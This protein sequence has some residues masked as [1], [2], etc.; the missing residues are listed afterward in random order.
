MNFTR[1]QFA[2]ACPLLGPTVHPLPANISGPQLLWA[3]GGNESSFGTNCTPRHE[4]AFDREGA[5][6]R[7]PDQ[8][9]LLNLYES[10]GAC[11]YG[12]LQIMLVNAKGMAPHDFD[13]LNRAMVASIQFLNSQL[14]RFKPQTLSQ[15]GA[16]WNGGSPRAMNPGVLA[17]QHRLMQNYNVPLGGA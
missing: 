2:A 9:N 8:A 7:E 13:D 12:P 4:P 16:L 1:Q 14:D 3:L 15:I 6:G 17:Y 11:S 10:A 5:Y